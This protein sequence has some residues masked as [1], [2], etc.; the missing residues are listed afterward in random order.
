MKLTRVLLDYSYLQ[1]IDIM[2]WSP[3]H[4]DRLAI[5]YFQMTDYGFSIIVSY[6]LISVES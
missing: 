3:D 5:H 4:K 6:K 1:H 2:L